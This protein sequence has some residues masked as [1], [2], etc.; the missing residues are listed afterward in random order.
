MI[1]VRLKSELVARPLVWCDGGLELRLKGLRVLTDGDTALDGLVNSID[2]LLLR[3]R[4]GDVFD[5]DGRLEA[6]GVIYAHS[7]MVR[8]TRA[9]EAV[10]W[11][12]RIGMVPVA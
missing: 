2:A 6:P 4:V 12:R 9:S 7:V 8:P 3:V 1:H 11:K 10:D 5:V